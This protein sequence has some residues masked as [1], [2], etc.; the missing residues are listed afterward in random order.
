MPNQQHCTKCDTL[1]PLD[2]DHWYRDAS[3]PTGF[4]KNW[5]KVC[6]KK[7]NQERARQLKLEGG[8]G[9]TKAEL[10]PPSVKSRD[11]DDSCSREKIGRD[12]RIVISM[13]KPIDVAIPL[14]DKQKKRNIMVFS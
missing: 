14:S 10:A 4:A 7:Y 6:T 8:Y 11:F 9:Y 1:K 2:A 3:N 12:H 5:C 13:F